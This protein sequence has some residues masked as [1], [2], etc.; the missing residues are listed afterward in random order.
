MLNQSRLSFKKKTDDSL[1]SNYKNSAN[2]IKS[3]FTRDL[4]VVSKLDFI[5]KTNTSLLNEIKLSKNRSIP[6]FQ[7][8]VTWLSLDSVDQRL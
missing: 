1:F 4:G 6:S 3:L 7:Q 8:S 2:L 5:V